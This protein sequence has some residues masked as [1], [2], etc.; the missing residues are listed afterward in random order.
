METWAEVNI[1]N[2]SKLAQLGVPVA[3]IPSKGRGRHHSQTEK[4]V[5]Q[6]VQC[7]LV[8]VGSQVLLTK[9]QLGLTGLGLNN[10]AIGQV[11]AIL[12]GPNATP[13]EF[14]EAIVVEFPNYKGPSW[15]PEHPKWIPIP[16]NEGRCDSM[17]CS[18]TGVPLMPGYAIPIAKSQ[19]MSI[20]ANKPATHARVKLQGKNTMEKLNL[21]LT[22]TALSRC[23]RENNWCLVEKIPEDRLLI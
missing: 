14:P 4:Q 5:G 6:I 19:G 8:A 15:F 9:N 20:G 1:E 7:S 13:P 17:C 11:I 22:Y 23:E 12:Y 21:G 3:I 2:H 16:V 18:R 10:G